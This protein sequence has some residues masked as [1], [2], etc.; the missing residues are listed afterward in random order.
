M[1]D[2][3]TNNTAIA[4]NNY[5][6]N[7][8]SQI[9]GTVRQIA[10]G[11]KISSAADNP[12]GLA[13][14]TQLQTAATQN[15]AVNQAG[16]AALSQLDTAT[17]QL[18]TASMQLHQASILAGQASQPGA[19]ISSINEQYQN[20]LQSIDQTLKQGGFTGT[21]SQI[22]T[23]PGTTV[24]VNLPNLS[25]SS[26]G[27]SKSLT[28]NNLGSA[29][30]N[31]DEAMNTVL[32]VAGQLAATQSVIQGDMAAQQAATL[33]AQAAQS[34]IADADVVAAMAQSAK[35]NTLNDAAAAALAQSNKMAGETLQLFK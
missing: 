16:T 26:L 8:Y 18:V 23:G 32:K 25:T 13:I 7:N 15:Q 35:L 19:D 4:A 27:L 6:N 17:D 1:L 3:Q 2:I 5:L 34:N 9:A 21:T 24:T 33:N 29:G 11:S 28:A 20:L 10:S 31:A 14:A 22:T 30:N 12:S